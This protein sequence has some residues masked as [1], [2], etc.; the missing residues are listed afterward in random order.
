M[1]ERLT[2][3]LPHVLLGCLCLGVASANAYRAHGLVVPAVA[4]GA[5]GASIVLTHAR[6]ALV[7]VALALVG[8]WWGSQP[9]LG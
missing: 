5:A 9:A 3:H 6:I 2:L 4:V 8:S 7:A 1:I